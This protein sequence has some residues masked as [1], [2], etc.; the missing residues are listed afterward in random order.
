M[1]MTLK[2]KIDVPV[3]RAWDVF[4]NQFAD[5]STW[6][7]GVFISAPQGHSALPY[8]PA[9]GR[10][11]QIPSGKIQEVIEAFNPELRQIRYKAEGP[12]FPF[13]VKFA[14]NTWQFTPADTSATHVQVDAHFA[15]KAP[16]SW[17]MSPLMK[18]QIRK[19][20]DGAV[21]ELEYYIKH[22]KPHPDKITFDAQPKAIKARQLA[23]A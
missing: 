18:P 6:I 5:I 21:R 8:A 20:M 23:L 4:A 14:R 11:C 19:V 7:S 15:L 1:K 16:F 22:G 10:V 13:I 2:Y 17:F 9:G 3:D 12:G